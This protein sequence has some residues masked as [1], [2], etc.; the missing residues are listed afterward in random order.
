MSQNATHNYESQLAFT[1]TATAFLSPGEYFPEEK[2]DPTST[3]APTASGKGNAGDEH[4]VKAHPHPLSTGAIVGIAIGGVLVLA[5]AGGIFYMCG[6]H[7]SFKEIM[8]RPS[9]S[10]K[11]GNGNA[12]GGGIDATTAYHPASPGLSEAHYPNIKSPAMSDARFS[13]NSYGGGGAD[14]YRSVSPPPMD[15]RGHSLYG[16]MNSGGQPSPGMPSPS[17]PGPAPHYQEM[18]EAD[19]SPSLKSP[20]YVFLSISTR[21]IL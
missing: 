12:N 20:G 10:S 17:W 18:H 14:S 9:S 11:N 19:S 13:G 8:K 21:L 4:D 6:R 1:Q 5:L 2:L 15:E 3:L 16:V 7:K